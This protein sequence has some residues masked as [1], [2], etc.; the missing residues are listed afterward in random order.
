MPVTTEGF[1]IVSDVKLIIFKNGVYKQVDVYHRK[2]QIFAATMGGYISLTRN[3]IT[4]V[5]S[6]E[7]KEFVA[8]TNDGFSYEIGEIGWLQLAKQDNAV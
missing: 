8:T 1:S 2:G 4:S 5:P 3:G 6:I 7:W